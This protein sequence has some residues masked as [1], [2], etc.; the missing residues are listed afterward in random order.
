MSNGDNNGSVLLPAILPMP[1][2][3]FDRQLT[4]TYLDTVPTTVTSGIIPSGSSFPT[5]PATGAL[6]F[7]TDTNILYLYDGTNWL[8]FP[9]TDSSGNLTISGRYLKG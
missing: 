6:F 9:T 2:T 8:E 5:S 1:Q 3:F 7:R 4:R